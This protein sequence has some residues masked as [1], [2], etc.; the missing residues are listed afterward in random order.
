[1]ND[2]LTKML[3]SYDDKQLKRMIFSLDILGKPLFAIFDGLPDNI[4][5]SVVSILDMIQE[6]T[7]GSEFNRAYNYKKGLRCYE[8]LY[9]LF[10]EE[11]FMMNF[12][13]FQEKN[14]FYSE[15]DESVPLINEDGTLEKMYKYV[16]IKWITPG[17]GKDQEE[18]DEKMRNYQDFVKSMI[19]GDYHIRA[20]K[21]EPIFGPV[22][23]GRYERGLEGFRIRFV[24]KA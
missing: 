11:K 5:Q 6:Y 15:E 19:P 18:L 8:E 14:G 16:N 23:A 24:F 12:K 17:F 9:H 1:M 20:D 4:A 2:Y 10:H 3:E 21:A 7:M 13:A 22:T